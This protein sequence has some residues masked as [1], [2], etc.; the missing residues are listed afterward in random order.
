MVRMESSRG[1]QWAV[2]AVT[3]AAV[4]AASWNMPM[5]AYSSALRDASGTRAINLWHSTQLHCWLHGTHAYRYG[6]ATN[7]CQ[8]LCTA[9][10]ICT[11][12]QT[13][14]AEA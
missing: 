5:A 11:F 10:A 9:M 1:V 8:P 4:S 12:S 14:S 7:L 2:G 13:A 3:V 6:T